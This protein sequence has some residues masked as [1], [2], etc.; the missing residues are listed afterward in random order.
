[1]TVNMKELKEIMKQEGNYYEATYNGIPFE[2]KRIDVLGH[3]CGYAYFDK[4]KYTHIIEDTGSIVVH[5]GITWIEEVDN[6]WMIGFDCSHS[7]YDVTP[8]FYEQ[9]LYD[10][11]NIAIDS[12]SFLYKSYKTKEFVIDECKSLINQVLGR[13]KTND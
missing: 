7:A 1:M 2:A 5:G 9:G 13:Y 6:Y 11:D 8:Y 4:S 12:M 3:W 10:S